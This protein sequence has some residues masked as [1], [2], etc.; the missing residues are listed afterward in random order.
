MEL[1]EIKK[2]ADF[3]RKDLPMGVW[4]NQKQVCWIADISTVTLWRLPADEKPQ[5]F[6]MAGSEM[7]E[8]DAAIRWAD[9]Y[10][11]R[12]EAKKARTK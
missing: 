7:I 8:I 10:W 4:M 3:I 11:R 1:K 2:R 12:Q 5:T 9:N 6:R